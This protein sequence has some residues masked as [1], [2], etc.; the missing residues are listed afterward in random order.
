[1]PPTVTITTTR[2]MLMGAA[3]A[4]SRKSVSS[5]ERL[6]MLNCSWNTLGPVSFTVMSTLCSAS[7]TK[8]GAGTGTAGPIISVR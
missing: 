3:P 5:G 4:V 2:R 8:R 1:M 6:L 7:R